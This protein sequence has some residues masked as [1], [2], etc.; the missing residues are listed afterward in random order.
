[1]CDQ[2]CVCVCL[3]CWCCC[4]WLFLL[5]QCNVVKHVV[6]SLFL[7]SNT[8]GFAPPTSTSATNNITMCLDYTAVTESEVIE[9]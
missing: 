3:C 1:M 9:T 6:V 4:V 5:M 2:W 8:H 7:I